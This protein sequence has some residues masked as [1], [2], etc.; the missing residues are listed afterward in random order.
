MFRPAREEYFII[1]C[2]YVTTT[3][4]SRRTAKRQIGARRKSTLSAIW[5]SYHHKRNPLF[6]QPGS[7]YFFFHGL[8][9]LNYIKLNLVV[10]VH[11]NFLIELCLLCA[12]LQSIHSFTSSIFNK[13]SS[14]TV[15]AASCW[16]A[17]RGI[18]HPVAR[19]SKL[20]L[21][22]EQSRGFVMMFVKHSWLLSSRP[23][24]LGW[25][26]ITLEEI[27]LLINFKTISKSSH[28]WR[29]LPMF[30]YCNAGEEVIQVRQQRS[31][32]RLEVCCKERFL[33]LK[34]FEWRLNI[35]RSTIYRDLQNSRH[36]F[37]KNW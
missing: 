25:K 10:C 21:L 1:Q 18:Q 22:V 3:Q 4:H 5:L 15:M 35:V 17:M 30:E 9:R 16:R 36:L 24:A 34:A 14:L 29:L 6:S 26:I 7:T 2:G 23:M 28:K 11:C 19:A 31:V 33:R 37:Y 12:L 13:S 8:V 32:K 27:S 20:P